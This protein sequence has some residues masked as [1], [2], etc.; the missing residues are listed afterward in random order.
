MVSIIVAVIAL[1]G[2][3]GDDE[4]PLLSSP[5]FAG[6]SAGAL[7]TCQVSLAAAVIDDLSGC[8]GPDVVAALQQAGIDYVVVA[9]RAG[10]VAKGLVVR[11]HPPPN[12]TLEPDQVVTLVVSR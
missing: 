8:P 9:I 6:A 3:H 7:S 5:P 11:Q 10:N 2:L 12:T 1:Y 4:S